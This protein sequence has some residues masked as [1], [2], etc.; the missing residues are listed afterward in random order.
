MFN[1]SGI[2]M[3]TYEKLVYL[4]SNTASKDMVLKD[5]GGETIDSIETVQENLKQEFSDEDVFLDFRRACETAV[6]DY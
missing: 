6:Y 4:A 3:N 1:Y 5:C 2:D